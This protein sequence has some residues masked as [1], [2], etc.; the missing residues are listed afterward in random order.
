LSTTRSDLQNANLRHGRQYWIDEEIKH[1]DHVTCLR[2]GSAL[3]TESRHDVFVTR[4]EW[5]V[6][7]VA[8]F[9][10]SSRLEVLKRSRSFQDLEPGALEALV[11]AA[12]TYTVK[13][14]ASVSCALHQG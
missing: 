3:V 2:D 12:Q 6:M 10:C 14:G 1:D 11:A 7:A 5:V 4:K 13:A 9:S 8:G